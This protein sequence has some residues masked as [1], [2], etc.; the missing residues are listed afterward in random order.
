MT[1]ADPFDEDMHHRIVKWEEKGEAEMGKKAGRLDIPLQAQ[2]TAI[3]S[4]ETN[5]GDFLTDAV[6]EMRQVGVAMVNGGTMR[7][8]KEYVDGELKKKTI[9][10]MHP[11]GNAIVKIYASGKEIKQYINDMLECWHKQCG[12]FIQ[13]S[14]LKYQFDSTAD[15]KRRLVKWM[16]LDGSEVHDD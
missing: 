6:R 11:F 15:K 1:D 5:M 10:E 12:S 7:G 13:I 8:D 16:E 14:G 9:V 3:R 2:N 4:G